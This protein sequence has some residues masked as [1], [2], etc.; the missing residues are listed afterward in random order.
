MPQKNENN[1]RRKNAVKIEHYSWFSL[2]R[3]GNRQ[4]L[5]RLRTKLCNFW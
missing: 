1:I 4:M 5:Y 3:V 2:W